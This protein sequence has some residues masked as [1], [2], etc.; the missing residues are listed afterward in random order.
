MVVLTA[1][2]SAMFLGDQASKDVQRH[3]FASRS[4]MGPGAGDVDPAVWS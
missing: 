1:A 2:L 3:H 4:L